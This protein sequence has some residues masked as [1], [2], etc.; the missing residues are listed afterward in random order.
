M[1]RK[2]ALTQTQQRAVERLAKGQ[3]CTCLDCGSADYLE[4]DTNIIQSFSNMMVALYCNNP[5]AEHAEGVLALG[6]S[7]PLSFAQADAIGLKVPPDDPR[8][9][10]AQAR[11]PP[12]P[13]VSSRLPS[14][15][16]LGTIWGLLVL[17]W[18][19][20]EPGID[21]TK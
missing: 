8:H 10:A 16:S 3:G 4:S 9:D 19:S 5:D 21:L 13:N 14:T 6:Q 7:F 1:R 20:A 11:R 12:A 18:Q 17:I 15:T 2:Q